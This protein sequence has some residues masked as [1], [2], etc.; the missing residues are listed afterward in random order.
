MDRATERLR[1]PAQYVGPIQRQLIE[2]PTYV[3]IASAKN[4]APSPRSGWRGAPL[5]QPTCKRRLRHSADFGTSGKKYGAADASARRARLDT[6]FPLRE[7]RPIRRGNVDHGGSAVSFIAYPG[8]SARSRRHYYLGAPTRLCSRRRRCASVANR[9]SAA[10]V[11][12]HRPASCRDTG[13]SHAWALALA[14]SRKLPR[15]R[16]TRATI[17]SFKGVSFLQILFEEAACWSG[18]L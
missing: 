5:N 7:F 9:V 1:L 8:G 13:S 2:L 18:R 15:S 4:C 12:S 14:S 16:S 3:L 6:G 17:A 10:R 11:R